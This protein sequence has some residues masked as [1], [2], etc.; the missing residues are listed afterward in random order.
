MIYRAPFVQSPPDVIDRMLAL[1]AIRPGDVLYDLG[2]GD[3]RVVIAAARRH[4]IRAV[5]FEIDPDLVRESRQAIESAGLA[6]L[7]EIHEQDILSADLSA[8]TVVTLYLQPDTNLRLR[9]VLLRGLRP[10]ARVVSHEFGMGRW[11]PHRVERMT[12]ADAVPRTIYLWRIG[13]R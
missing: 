13:D 7:T 10:G 12:D 8:A 1:A 9:P 4:G 5:G 11:R 6:G 2:S 3:G